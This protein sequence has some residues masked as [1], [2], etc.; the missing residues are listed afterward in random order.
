MKKTEKH[1]LTVR[2]ALL[3]MLDIL[4]MQVA[5]FAS[6]WIR[7]EFDFQ[8]VEETFIHTVWRYMPLNILVTL[9]VFSMFHLYTSLWK[10]A[11][12]TELS[13]LAEILHSIA[14]HMNLQ[15][16]MESVSLAKVIL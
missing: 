5:S 1:A 2:I 7:H 13:C 4:F 12:I 11:S 14:M 15:P 10:Y 9:A 6:L 3:V 8:A 16:E